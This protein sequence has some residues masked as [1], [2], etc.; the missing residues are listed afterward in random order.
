MERG[1]MITA[2]IQNKEFYLYKRLKNQISLSFLQNSAS[3]TFVL[4][5]KQWKKLIIFFKQSKSCK[6]NIFKGFDIGQN[7]IDSCPM[8]RCVKEQALLEK[9]YSK[10]SKIIKNYKQAA[11]ITKKSCL[12]DYVTIQKSGVFA[13]LDRAK[14]IRFREFILKSAV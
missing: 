1:A 10:N 5:D 4:N 8:E 11:R 2:I 9:L 13:N 14:F 3:Y 6:K 7:K 12:E